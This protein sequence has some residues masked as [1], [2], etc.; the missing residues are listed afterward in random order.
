MVL[1]ESVRDAADLWLSL[2]YPLVL[3]VCDTPCT[4]A[5]LINSRELA[6]QYWGEMTDVLKSLKPREI[7]TR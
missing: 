7:Q 6:N 3:F 5:H 2:R 4:F 1:K